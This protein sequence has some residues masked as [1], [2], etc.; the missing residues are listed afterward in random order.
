METTRLDNAAPYS[1]PG[2]HDMAAFRLQ[3]HGASSTEHFW[4]GLSHFLPGGGAE[5]SATP[6]EKVYVVVDGQLTFVTDEGEEVL[7]PLDSC[8]FAPGEART[9]ENRSNRVASMLVVMPYPP[10]G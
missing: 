7:G 9:V 6:I 10:A 2:H 3:G 5:R 4:V 1:A 8:R